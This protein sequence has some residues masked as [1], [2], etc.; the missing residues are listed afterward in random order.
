MNI[1]EPIRMGMDQLRAHKMRAFLSILG[2]LI[3]VGSVT[4]IV[5]M[6]DGLRVTVTRQFEQSGGSNALRI[7]P[8]DTW[9]RTE[10]GAW[11]QRDW[12]AYLE[13]RDLAFLEN[14]LEHVEF[15]VPLSYFGLTVNYKEVAASANIIGTNEHFLKT[16]NWKIEKGRNISAQDVRAASKVVVLG[17]QIAED[18]FGEQDPVGKELKLQGVRFQVIGVLAP[19]NLLGDTNSRNMIGPYTVAQ[20][21]FTGNEYHDEIV[22]QATSPEYAEQVARQIRPVLKRYH[23]HGS[24]YR[25][26]TGQEMLDQFNRVVFILN[27]IAGGIAGISLLVGGIGIMNIML[28]SVSER[29]REIGIR[30][31]LGA[32]NSSILGQFMLEAVVLC[33]FGGGLGIL[34]GIIIGSGIALW[35]QNISGEDFVSIITPEL[36]LFA[37]SYSSMIG[38]FFGV[39]PAWRASK[40]DPIDALRYE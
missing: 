32:K 36:M 23:E 31:A 15:V 33:L 28:V 29:T 38:L 12:E 19:Y 4:G 10:S 22:V 6:G 20:K 13:N 8:P 16:Q 14:E 11:R 34:L 26:E 40:L 1:L 39:Y 24:E 18:L 9:Y 21:R 35:I 2:I 27:A 17:S 30:K 5:S 3:S 25:V 7:R 37:I